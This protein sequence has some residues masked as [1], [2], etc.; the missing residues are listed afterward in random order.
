VLLQHET[1]I[2]R[3]DDVE[4]IANIGSSRQRCVD[5]LTRLDGERADSCRMLSFGQEPA[6]L[7]SYMPGAIRAA[8]STR[9]GWPTCAS[10]VAVSD[11]TT[12]MARWSQ[13]NCRACSS[14]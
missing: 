9:S 8:H 5:A 4:A 13:P 14:C 3:G 1:A 7:P 11:S 2:L 12:P 10:P 6:R